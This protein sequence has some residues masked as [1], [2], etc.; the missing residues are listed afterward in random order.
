MPTHISVLVACE[1]YVL[2]PPNI[3]IAA[4]LAVVQVEL[5]ALLELKAIFMQAQ[6]LGTAGDSS[7]RFVNDR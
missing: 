4:V 2:Q 3:R 5:S 6:M 1:S 7:K